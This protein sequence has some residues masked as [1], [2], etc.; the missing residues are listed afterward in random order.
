MGQCQ[1]VEKVQPLTFEA[2]L[3]MESGWSPESAG[4]HMNPILFP[5]LAFSS[6]RV[7]EAHRSGKGYTVSV[8][9]V[10]V[11]VR[12]FRRCPGPK[13]SF[14]WWISKGHLC[15][16]YAATLA[17]LTFSCSI[18]FRTR[19]V[20]SMTPISSVTRWATTQAAHAP[21]SWKRR[22]RTAGR[23]HQKQ[24]T[25]RDLKVSNVPSLGSQPN[26]CGDRP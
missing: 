22:R 15:Q 20:S 10:S 2:P 6:G 1:H 13:F 11:F 12:R 4:R 25:S 3:R 18:R 14:P 24:R 26:M 5:S 19:E 21:S 7:Q 17:M 23:C 9:C 16:S 8:Y